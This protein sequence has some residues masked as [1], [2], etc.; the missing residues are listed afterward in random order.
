MTPPL[1]PENLEERVIYWS[2]IGTWVFWV[3]GG[4]YLLAP[5]IGWTLLCISTARRLGLSKVARRTDMTAI[6]V[7]CKIWFVSMGIMAVGLIKGHI[8]FDLEAGQI[9][10]SFIGWMKGWALIA[11]F[12]FVGATMSIR[13]AI[14]YRA[15]NQLALQTIC[16]VPLFIVAA[17]IHLP[18]PLYISPLQIV[19]GPGPEF[20]TVELYGIEPETGAARWRFFAPWAPAAALVSNIAFVFALYDR[21]RSWKFIGIISS[22]VVCLMSQSR[23]GLVAVPTIV[24]VVL[25]LSNVTRSSVFLV[26]TAASAL[27]VPFIGL[28][29]Q[30][31]NDFIDKFQNAR[32][33]SS[34]VRG[35]LQRIAIH[36]WWNEAPIWGHGI[37]ERGPH[38][39]EYMPIG[40]HH[41][42]NGLLYVKGV[43]GLVALAVPLIWSFLEIFI[44]SQADITARCSLGVIIVLALYSFGENLEI[45]VYLLWPGLIIIGISTGRRFFSPF[46]R[47]LGLRKMGNKFSDVI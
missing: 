32:A 15:S 39:V 46:H 1:V 3:V 27:V 18:R 47:S 14:V 28:L 20:F 4:L 24:V 19:G 26:G 38:L 23:M 35:T 29:T 44:K 30:S 17:Y 40:S 41:T 9:I 7:G 34:R 2:I 5:A 22:I 8:D 10:K 42:W 25:I 12:I 13:P 21:S 11:V 36:R 43:V 16:L 31:I 37:V 45:L 6:P 33:S